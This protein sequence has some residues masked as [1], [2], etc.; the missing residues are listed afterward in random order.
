MFFHISFFSGFY[1]YLC[2][3]AHG[4]N[5]NVEA[6]VWCTYVPKIVGILSFDAFNKSDF[7]ELD[8]P[9]PDQS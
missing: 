3:Q 7:F 6:V 9:I 8:L 5:I 4:P 1:L 2:I